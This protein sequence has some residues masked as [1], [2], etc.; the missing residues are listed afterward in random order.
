MP[1][2]TRSS[3]LKI[4]ALVSITVLASIT[5]TAAE[6]SEPETRRLSLADAVS[7]G[8]GNNPSVELARLQAE[9]SRVGLEQAEDLASD[10]D[11]DN[12]FSMEQA[13]MKYLNPKH[14]AFALEDDEK[15]LLDARSG[16]D[17]AIRQAYF[18]ALLQRE[19][20]SV[21]ETALKSADQQLAM[22]QAA[23]KAGTRAKLDV[24]A[25]ESA[26]AAAKADLSS[27][28]KD[29]KVAVMNLNKTIGLP[30][31]TDLEL[32]TPLE[33][34]PPEDIDLDAAINSAFAQNLGLSKATHAASLASLKLEITGRY[35]TPNTYTYRQAELEHK[36]AVAKHNSTKVDV[37]FQVRKSYLD[38]L[39][40]FERISQQHAAVQAA[41]ENARL[42]DLRYK[43]GLGTMA[44]ALE[45][46]ARAS[47]ARMALSSAVFSYNMA[48]VGFANLT[49]K[50]MR[51]FA[52]GE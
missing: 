4:V 46:Q 1:R 16:I 26:R 50:D 30:L 5:G 45:V 34:T 27:A 22:A 23:Y 18:S 47:A 51:S 21:R 12:I 40:A 11:G 25:A 10:I 42:A 38:T 39:D 29:Y 52:R 33:E 7:L 31:T 32:T 19:L 17:L 20:L 36:Q 41:E 13:F 24:L 49:G 6:N 3:L 15:A 9:K 35:Y 8:M 37:E 28:T 48:R 43:A 2:L 14:A 44:E